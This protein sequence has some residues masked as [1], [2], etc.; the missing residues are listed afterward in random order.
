MRL[1]SE[2]MEVVNR[3]R[4]SSPFQPRRRPLPFLNTTNVSMAVLTYDVRRLFSRL[5]AASELKLTLP[6]SQ[7]LP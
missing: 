2:L 4:S 7:P 5:A 6:F 1:V 3:A